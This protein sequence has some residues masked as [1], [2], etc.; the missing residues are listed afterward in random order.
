MH[1]FLK[2]SRNDVFFLVILHMFSVI[3]QEINM[4]YTT[5]I[6]NKPREKKNVLGI[7]NDG[8]D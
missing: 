5:E 6:W 7:S 1:G 3:H 2:K 8:N 4:H